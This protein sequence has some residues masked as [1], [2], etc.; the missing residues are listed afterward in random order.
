MK[1]QKSYIFDLK[2][3]IGKWQIELRVFQAFEALSRS[4]HY[5]QIYG[6]DH[7][8]QLLL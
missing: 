4:I 5:L 1:Q 7:M 8:K 6:T 2:S 3:E